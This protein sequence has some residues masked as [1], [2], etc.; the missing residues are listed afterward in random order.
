MTS[1]RLGVLH[2]LSLVYE[3]APDVTQLPNPPIAH[4]LTRPLSMG[5]FSCA[6]TLATFGSGAVYAQHDSCELRGSMTRSVAELRD[7]GTPRKQLQQTADNRFGKGSQSSEA[8]FMRQT[9]LLVYKDFPRKAPR[10]IQALAVMGC[11][12]QR[13]SAN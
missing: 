1:S 11:L 10:E 9:I 4:W 12:L 6:L 5:L 3:I 2:N 7:S 8:V 13:A